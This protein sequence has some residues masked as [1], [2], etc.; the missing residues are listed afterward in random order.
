V[1]DYAPNRQGLIETLEFFAALCQVTTMHHWHKD[2][3]AAGLLAG[4][5]RNRQDNV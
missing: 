1:K 2:A 3:E 4:A 5:L